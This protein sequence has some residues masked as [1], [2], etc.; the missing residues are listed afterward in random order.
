MLGT[1]FIRH[2]VFSPYALLHRVEVAARA[3][4]LHLDSVQL[5]GKF[6]HIALPAFQRFLYLAA[7]FGARVAVGVGF[8]QAHLGRAQCLGRAVLHRARFI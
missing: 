7:T 5:I 4:D 6:V 3:V 8:G 1:G 2:F